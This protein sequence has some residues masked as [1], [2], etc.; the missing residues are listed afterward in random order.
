MNTVNHARAVS[1]VDQ[2]YAILGGF[3]LARAKDDELEQTIEAIKA[4]QPKLIVPSHCTGFQATA[5]FA[6]HL[7]KAFMPNVV[8]A[9]YLF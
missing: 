9:T 5:Q 4:F 3:H 6:A 8:G 7:P 1:G 2:V